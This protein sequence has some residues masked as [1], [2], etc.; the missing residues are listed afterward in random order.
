[1][2]EKR[3]YQ[4]LKNDNAKLRKREA[5]NMAAEILM[6]REI[7]RT[8]AHGK[9]LELERK[10][11]LSKALEKSL[12]EERNAALTRAYSAEG[13]VG[14]IWDEKEA[15]RIQNARLQVGEGVSG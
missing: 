12:R 8:A 9:A 13:A 1:M 3:L 5:Q 6:G 2:K 4:I 7:D 10:L 11:R 15:L 14:R